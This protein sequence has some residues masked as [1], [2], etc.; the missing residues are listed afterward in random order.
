MSLVLLGEG[1]ARYKGE[2]ME[3]TEALKVAGLTR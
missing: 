1:K 3:A 2:W